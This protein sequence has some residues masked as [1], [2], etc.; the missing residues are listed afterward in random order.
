MDMPFTRFLPDSC[1]AEASELFEANASLPLK[2]RIELLIKFLEEKEKELKAG[3]CT[4]VLGDMNHEKDSGICK[5][6][7]VGGQRPRAWLPTAARAR[8][9]P[10]GRRRAE[11]RVR[12]GTVEQED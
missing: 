5:G 7:G 8:R 6:V 1:Y 4:E 10:D 2:Q 11:E 9:R 3:T 12:E